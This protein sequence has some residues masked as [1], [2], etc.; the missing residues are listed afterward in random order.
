MA[1]LYT[2]YNLFFSGPCKAVLPFGTVVKERAPL[3]K[4]PIALRL[5]VTVFDYKCRDG[6][7]L[8]G[9]SRRYCAFYR[10]QNKTAFFPVDTPSPVCRQGKEK[11]NSSW[12]PYMWSGVI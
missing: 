12:R 7:R 9:R 3:G 5:D 4:H 6:F 2:D 10:E 8:V 11:F 1:D